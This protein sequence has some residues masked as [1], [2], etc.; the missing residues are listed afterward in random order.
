[1]DIVYKAQVFATAAHYAVKQ[2]RKY[3]GEPYI[4]HPAEVVAI[5]Y[6]YGTTEEQAAAGWLHDTVE[7][8]GVTSEIIYFEFGQFSINA[9]HDRYEFSF[10]ASL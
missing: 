5:L 9:L 2:T 7:D 8:T 4:V 6:K 3:T 1:M 10:F